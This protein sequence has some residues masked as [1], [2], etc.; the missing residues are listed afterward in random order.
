MVEGGCG[1][2]VVDLGHSSASIFV[3]G[4]TGGAFFGGR[5][6]VAIRCSCQAFLEGQ[7]GADGGGG[8]CA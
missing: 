6:C 7:V 8:G 5:G 3:D 1:V 4:F 2:S